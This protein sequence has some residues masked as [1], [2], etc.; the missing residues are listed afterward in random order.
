MKKLT[1]L[2][3]LL[4]PLMAQAQIAPEMK[5]KS[6]IG[7]NPASLFDP[8][9]LTMRQS[10]S[11][12]YYTGGGRSGNIGLYMNSIE[13]AF[14]DPLK[15]RVDLGFLHTPSQLISGS[16]SI[17]DNGVIVPGISIDWRPTKS[18]NLRLD[19]RQHA[20][21]YRWFGGDDYERYNLREEN[22]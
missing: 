21:T 6:Y 13:Y 20:E 14:S 3:I 12:M 19:Y 11:F 2:M 1:V 16:T 9:K 15:I 5:N 17:T 7:E 8:S 18:F 10:Y 22:R 4:I